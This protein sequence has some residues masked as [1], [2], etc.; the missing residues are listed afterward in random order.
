MH[1]CSHFSS[2][3]Q[4][5]NFQDASFENFKQ[6]FLGHLDVHSV[7][8]LHRIHIHLT[9]QNQYFDFHS[10]LSNFIRRFKKM[11]LSRTPTRWRCLEAPKECPIRKYS[12]ECFAPYDWQQNK[13]FPHDLQAPTAKNESSYHQLKWQIIILHLNYETLNNTSMKLQKWR[14][15]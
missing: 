4:F 3:M 7:W 6:L 13:L 2:W 15:M 14:E 12:G 11:P 10:I 8:E 5:F 1:R 9:N